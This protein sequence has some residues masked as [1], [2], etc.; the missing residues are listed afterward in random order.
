VDRGLHS[1]GKGYHSGPIVTTL[2]RG[3]PSGMKV[4]C[5]E[6]EVALRSGA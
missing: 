4:H 5:K 3:A 2:L 1:R 6:L